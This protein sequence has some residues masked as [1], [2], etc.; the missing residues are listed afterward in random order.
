[1]VLATAGA[2]PLIAV[3]V[4]DSW[5]P[6]ANRVRRVVSKLESRDPDQVLPMM[7]EATAKVVEGRGYDAGSR[8]GGPLMIRTN[9]PRV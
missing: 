6:A 4:T 8:V 3:L 2:V 7:D 5:L 1:M 9:D